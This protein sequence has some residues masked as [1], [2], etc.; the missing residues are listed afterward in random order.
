MGGVFSKNMGIVMLGGILFSFI[1]TF[2]VV[3]AA[4]YKAL[5]GHGRQH[6][7]SGHVFHALGG[8]RRAAHCAPQELEDLRPGGRV[9]FSGSGLSVVAE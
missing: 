5:L 2:F 8:V 3:P 4:F 7:L 1:L 9:P 6:R